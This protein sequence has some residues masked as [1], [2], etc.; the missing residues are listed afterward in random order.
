M[1]NEISQTEKDKYHMI[2][3]IQNLRNKKNKLVENLLT[4]IEDNM[5]TARGEW[6]WRDGRKG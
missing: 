4:N 6:D 1:L 2:S 3:H 5:T